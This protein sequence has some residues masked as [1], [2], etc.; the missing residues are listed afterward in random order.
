[1]I[2]NQNRLAY[3][4]GI[5]DLQSYRTNALNESTSRLQERESTKKESLVESRVRMMIREEIKSVLRKMSQD[6]V[7]KSLRSNDLKTAMGF[8]GHG[9]SSRNPTNKT[10]ARTATTVSFGGPGFM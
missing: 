3:L 8:A 5:S 2:W 9:F 7:E 6:N 10:S 1:M 4:S